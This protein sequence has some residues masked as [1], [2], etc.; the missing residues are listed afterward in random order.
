MGDSKMSGELLE[1]GPD[2]K[3]SYTIRKVAEDLGESTK[4][5]NDMVV[6][7]SWH[8]LLP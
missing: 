7:R 5:A 3:G 4:K 6:E 8:N 1:C 2:N